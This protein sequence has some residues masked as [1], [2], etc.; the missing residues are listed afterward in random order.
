V[1]L[2]LGGDGCTV[3]S[4][5]AKRVVFGLRDWVL[6]DLVYYGSAVCCRDVGDGVV[7]RGVATKRVTRVPYVQC[8]DREGRGFVI[9]RDSG[10]D[11]EERLP[12]ACF[13]YKKVLTGEDV[14][15]AVNKMYEAFRSFIRKKHL[16][17]DE[18]MNVVGF[19]SEAVKAVDMYVKM[20][21]N[22]S[23]KDLVVIL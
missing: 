19:S 21:K 6:D 7:C 17:V 3:V 16:I 22:K 4:R 14:R 18:G 15:Y 5:D 8:V 12:V 10:L 11:V 20:V 1:Y 23:V 9:N 2:Y 13:S